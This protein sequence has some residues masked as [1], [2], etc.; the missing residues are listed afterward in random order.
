[1]LVENGKA[2]IDTKF[3][4]AARG[5]TRWEVSL[6]VYYLMLRKDGA[7][8]QMNEVWAAM[9]AGDKNELRALALDCWIHLDELEEEC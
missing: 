6:A 4:Y 1:M 2:V 8:K 7:R 3:P 5:I 9:S